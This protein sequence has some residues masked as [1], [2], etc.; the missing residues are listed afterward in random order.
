MENNNRERNQI[1]NSIQRGK[2]MQSNLARKIQKR[3]TKAVEP[4]NPKA[5]NPIKNPIDERDLPPFQ[6]GK[7]I[8]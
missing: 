6:A 4:N 5:E 3:N 2:N 7:P 1:D 8:V